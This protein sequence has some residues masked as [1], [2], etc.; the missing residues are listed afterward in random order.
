M[1]DLLLS[2]ESLYSEGY[3]CKQCSHEFTKVE[4]ESAITD[5]GSEPFNGTI[6]ECPGT[7]SEGDHCGAEYSL[8]MKI[9]ITD[10]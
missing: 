9:R 5:L 6:L 7:D 2:P 4:L 1:T 10:V 8:D 3:S